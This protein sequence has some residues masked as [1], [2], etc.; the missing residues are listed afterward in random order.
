MLFLTVL[1]F[2]A[3]KPVCDDLDDVDAVENDDLTYSIACD[4]DPK[5]VCKWT[6]DGKAIDTKDGHFVVSEESGVYK[7]TIKPVTMD[8]KGTYQAEFTNRAGEKK[9]QSTMNVLCEYTASLRGCWH[10]QQRTKF[11]V[12][13]A[14][15]QR[16]R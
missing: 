4:G 16:E 7:L 12:W 11:F 13:E 3:A 1:C 10:V 15:R 9:V 2:L 5:P 14:R 8:D 6:K